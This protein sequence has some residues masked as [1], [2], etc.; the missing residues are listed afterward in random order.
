M[1]VIFAG[2]AMNVSPYVLHQEKDRVLISSPEQVISLTPFSEDAI[3]VQVLA[4]GVT[5]KPSFVVVQPSTKPKFRVR[6]EAGKYVITTAR[7]KVSVDQITGSIQFQDDK[8][9][10]FLSEKPGTRMLQPVELQGK[11]LFRV[12]QTFDSPED[13]SLFGLGQFQNGLWNW[14]G[15]PLELCQLNTQIALPVLVSSRG[16]GLLWDNASRTDFNPADTEVKLSGEVAQGGSG[17]TATE[18]LQGGPRR[19]HPI[20]V[21]QG[22][23]VPEHP[24]AYALCVR[25]GD[26]RDEIAILVNGKPVND[27]V[28]MWTP[29]GIEAKINLTSREPVQVSVRGGGPGVKLFVRPVDDTT[30]F[31]SDY[32]EG[33]D[34]TV[35]YGPNLDRVVTLYR[36]LTGNAPMFPKWAFGFW[37][38]RERYSSQEQILSTVSEFRKRKIPLD[39]IVQDWQYWGDHG[40]GSYEWD[41]KAY[42]EPK[43]MISRLHEKDVKFM[44][45]VWCNPQGVTRQDLE[46]NHALTGNWIDVF[47]ETGRKIRWDH[48]NQ[49]FFS[50]GTDA[51]WGDATEPGD[52]GTEILDQPTAMGPGA[53]VTSAYPLFASK[54]IYDGQRAADPSKRVCTLTRSAF[55]G[56]QRY[57]AAAW[58]GDVKGDWDALQR[59]IPA[60]LNFS[61]A[62][63]PYWTTDTAGFFRPYGQYTSADYNELL[64][65]WFQWSTFCP[66]LRVHGYQTTTEMWHYLPETQKILQAFDELRYR[67]LPYNYSVAWQVTNHGASFLRPLGMDFANQPEAWQVSDAYMYGPSLFVA[68]ITEAKA[69]HRTVYLPKAEGNWFDFWTDKMI[70]GGTTVTLDASLDKIPLLVR[71]GSILP[72]GPVLQ[73]TAEKSSEPTEIRVYPGANGTFTLYDDAGDG[74]AY[75]KGERTVIPMTWSDKKQVLHI[76]SQSGSYPGM[77]TAREFN[78]RVV[79]QAAQHVRYSGKS[80]DVKL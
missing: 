10:H 31:R 36:N 44:I 27:L 32:G 15:V 59:Q 73:S 56:M 50:I 51:W 6:S 78:V 48:L 80:L 47:G 20:G 5:A 38:C 67:F 9:R 16:Y 26:R 46:K 43:E 22:T 8:G 58:T 72:L 45:S 42:P 77:P 37:Q 68:P 62:G 11:S 71:A 4:S 18:Q 28:N 1:L 34:Y 39:L 57:G 30:T 76:G 21:L 35:F 53:L 40:W 25:G 24:G 19:G 75:E 13:E 63:I 79:G 23:F 12:G 66:I 70:E 3:R 17:P 49:A 64:V 65:R 52:P 7:L 60:G 2:L 54:S 14:K 41:R 61:L 74:Y 55:P 69:T 29:R 33:I